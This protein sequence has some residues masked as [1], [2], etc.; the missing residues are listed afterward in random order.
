[1]FFLFCSITNYFWL[2]K[3]IDKNFIPLLNV[4]ISMIFFLLCVDKDTLTS[5]IFYAKGLDS[6]KNK[7]P[8]ADITI[9]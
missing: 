6:N 7:L 2:R 1:M 9:W 5:N 3:L 8:N 4:F